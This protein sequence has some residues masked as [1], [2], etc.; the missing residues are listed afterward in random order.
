MCW[1]GGCVYVL[2][3]VCCICMLLC[4]GTQV[5]A[6]V[7]GHVCRCV[8]RPKSDGWRHLISFSC[9]HLVHWD[10]AL[11]ESSLTFLLVC[12]ASLL[13]DALPGPPESWVSYECWKAELHSD[14]HICIVSA[15]P[16][17]PLPRPSAGI[18]SALVLLERCH[19]L[20]SEL[21]DF[22]HLLIREYH[23]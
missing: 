7:C 10:R 11:T 12:L 13:Q 15:L 18:F 1:W 2:V 9:S 14:P 5:C 3:C 6:G 17:C 20:M 4:M 8:Q 23:S 19:W 16:I 21:T 22:P